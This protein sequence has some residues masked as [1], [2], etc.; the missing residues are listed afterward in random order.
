MGREGTVSNR[1]SQAGHQVEVG[2]GVRSGTHHE[3]I[4]SRHTGS[5]DFRE[6]VQDVIQSGGGESVDLLGCI[7]RQGLLGQLERQ[8]RSEDQDE[9]AA[10]GH[11]LALFH[12]NLH[13]TPLP[14]LQHCASLL[15]TPADVM[16]L[17]VTP[18]VLVQLAGTHQQ[19]GALQ[20]L[21]PGEGRRRIRGQSC[22]NTQCGLCRGL[23]PELP[24]IEAWIPIPRVPVPTSRGGPTSAAV[25]G[26]LWPCL[27]AAVPPAS[28]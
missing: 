13:E 9:G 2:Q 5:T 20:G 4:A 26:G 7:L 16:R 11:R 18:E 21:C 14:G 23:L 3:Q 10:S 17:V 28:A 1:G 6:S 12:T 25:L 19:E 27:P 15:L 8:G 24:G 22:L